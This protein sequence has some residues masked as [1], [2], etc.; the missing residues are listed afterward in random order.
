MMGMCGWGV[1]I[2]P[3]DCLSFFIQKWYWCLEL[4]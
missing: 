4:S 1:V 2:G 3:K